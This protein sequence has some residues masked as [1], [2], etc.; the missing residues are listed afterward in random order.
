[1]SEASAAL[2]QQRWAGMVSALLPNLQAMHR[3]GKAYSRE[4]RERVMQAHRAGE[5]VRS[6]A[7][8][9]VL[10]RKTVTKYV[11]A[12]DGDVAIPMPKPRGGTRLPPKVLPEH[13]L[14]L[15]QVAAAMPRLTLGDM[16]QYLRTL[17][18]TFPDVDRSTLSKLLSASGLTRQI[19]NSTDPAKFKGY[20]RRAEY[21]DF[22]RQQCRDSAPLNDVRPT[23]DGAEAEAASEQEDRPLGPLTKKEE[24]KRLRAEAMAKTTATLEAAKWTP[25]L[26]GDNLLFIDETNVPMVL[27]QY[28]QKAWA[29]QGGKAYYSAT[30]GHTD[31][32]NLIVCGGLIFHPENDYRDA[33]PR[34]GEE[35]EEAKQLRREAYRSAVE[36]GSDYGVAVGHARDTRPR[37]LPGDLPVQWEFPP[38]P[39]DI[40]I[41]RC[42]ADQ[43]GRPPTFAERSEMRPRFCEEHA[44]R[45]MVRSEGPAPYGPNEYLP[46][47]RFV[48]W[49][50]KLSRRDDVALPLLYGA[51]EPTRAVMYPEVTGAQGAKQRGKDKAGSSSRAAE[52]RGKQKVSEALLREELDAEAEKTL[53]NFLFVNGVEDRHVSEQGELHPSYARASDAEL[54]RRARALDQN[55]WAGLPR[56]FF[57][58]RT[59]K[60]GEVKAFTGDAYEF[61]RF[62]HFVSLCVHAFFGEK[63]MGDMRVGWDNAST[64]GSVV[65]TTK[66]SS[67]LHNYL[68]QV[69]G[70]AG[71]VHIPPNTP[72]LDPVEAL[73]NHTKATISTLSLPPL[74]KF[75][76][77]EVVD[78]IR[79][80]LDRVK[81]GSL[82][83]WFRASGYGYRSPFAR[84]HDASVTLMEPPGGGPP[85]LVDRDGRVITAASPST[86][87]FCSHGQALPDVPGLQGL[88][89]DLAIARVYLDAAF[90]EEV[91]RWV[92]SRAKVRAK[93]GSES[94]EVNPVPHGEFAPV[95]LA[96]EEARL[97]LRAVPLRA[98]HRGALEAVA[99]LY[100]RTARFVTQLDARYSTTF[101]QTSAADIR[102]SYF[103]ADDA[104]F[105]LEGVLS[106]LRY[107]QATPNR[108]AGGAGAGGLPVCMDAKGTLI[109]RIAPGQK[110]WTFLRAPSRE[111]T[112]YL[113][114]ESAHDLVTR[115]MAHVSLHGV[116][117]A[118]ASATP[119]PSAP[120]QATPVAALPGAGLDWWSVPGQHPA[121]AEI[122]R[123]F[124]AWVVERRDD[125]CAAAPLRQLLSRPLDSVEPVPGSSSA[126]R[127]RLNDH[128]V[129]V[130]L[131]SSA[132]AARGARRVALPMTYPDWQEA[133]KSMD[134]RPVPRQEQHL[135]AG[136]WCFPNEART[137]LRALM[138]HLLVRASQ[139]VEVTQAPTQLIDLGALAP[140]VTASATRQS[141]ALKD[142]ANP[143][144]RRWPG[145]PRVPYSD[146]LRRLRDCVLFNKFK[147]YPLAAA[148]STVSHP[149]VFVWHAHD[150]ALWGPWAG[151]VLF[152]AD[153]NATSQFVVPNIRK[154]EEWNP[155][156]AD[157]MKAPWEDI[158][159][160][161]GAPVVERAVF[162]YAL[163]VT[164][165]EF[166]QLREDNGGEGEAAVKALVAILKVGGVYSSIAKELSEGGAQ[167]L[168]EFV[169]GR[170]KEEE[171]GT[172]ILANVLTRKK[173][174][175]T[176]LLVFDCVHARDILLKG[177]PSLTGALRSG[178][179]FKTAMAG[180]RQDEAAPAIRYTQCLTFAE[181]E[182]GR[183]SA[184]VAGTVARF[185]IRQLV[186]ALT[187]EAEEQGRTAH[188]DADKFARQLLL[189]AKNTRSGASTDDVLT[190]LS[191][192]AGWDSVRSQVVPNAP[193]EFRA[194]FAMCSHGGDWY[195]VDE[196][197]QLFNLSRHAHRLLRACKRRVEENKARQ[198]QKVETRRLPKVHV[199]QMQRAK[200]PGDYLDR[201]LFGFQGSGGEFVDLTKTAARGDT[202]V[203]VKQSVLHGETLEPVTART[204]Q[205]N[206]SLRDWPA[207]VPHMISKSWGRAHSY[208]TPGAA[209][210]AAAAAN[211]DAHPESAPFVVVS[212]NAAAVTD[213]SRAPV[214]GG[215]FYVLKHRRIPADQTFVTRYAPLFHIRETED[216]PVLEW[217]VGEE[218]LRRM[219]RAVRGVPPATDL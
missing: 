213:S 9:L 138:M 55:K 202:V 134:K 215:T 86:R 91:N 29:F 47:A 178:M 20:A 3:G 125:L 155:R 151:H 50:S 57:R 106:N 212:G 12:V 159:M 185:Y 150:A 45:G 36:F 22:R 203:S 16:N 33:A 76:P 129:H 28:A 136:A 34:A 83:S 95:H 208:P 13:R 5:S 148:V 179:P 216:V 186:E 218:V 38:Q 163:L 139:H 40:A 82:F 175:K 180:T 58:G 131:R 116:G 132:A 99:A 191:E 197:D 30:K 195:I 84:L 199:E 63:V 174:S 183:P 69:Y 109:K 169:Q 135:K 187:D 193:A 105:L 141:A 158:E 61:L 42:T 168:L 67:G 27:R 206:A 87:T 196:H 93:Y 201:Y 154:W 54:L 210:Q 219:V 7:A 122:A 217:R 160:Q 176:K 66:T 111:S 48:A 78:R 41:P 18:P 53:M 188:Q 140:Y 170:E 70:I 190:A 205:R 161:L 171:P 162:P 198:L 165:E 119:T 173:N 49:C 114:S 80:A 130:V 126:L 11:G 120:V 24:A 153:G 127:V 88:Q 17:D 113:Q 51:A 79:Y 25:T 26:H 37:P 43:C 81:S 123:V 75:S 77:H 121:L 31:R 74:G 103:G 149:W 100:S 60:G 90:Q 204:L 164:I 92:D 181:Y 44:P 214:P 73:I 94:A 146:N 89:D 19:I 10:D 23:G 1:M 156:M 145:Y 166:V 72:A 32:V 97:S 207:S 101:R 98:E 85:V 209:V 115:G 2:V 46:G 110:E 56:R 68:Q 64:H 194:M 184:E 8:R 108:C 14:M 102:N 65:A 137:G 124:G 107:S 35:T 157:I 52:Q 172:W 118:L 167:D 6:I 104:L 59:Y 15:V 117:P 112:A 39:A 96:E 189:A 133:L 143:R 177:P 62:V 211:G 147:D 144:Q 192:V 152:P 142:D 182:R 21:R 200:R 4:I 71:I 128:S